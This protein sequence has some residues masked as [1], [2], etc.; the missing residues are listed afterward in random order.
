MTASEDNLTKDLQFLKQ[1]EMSSKISMQ[2]EKSKHL[3]TFKQS[4][5]N[6][7][8]K[9]FLQNQNFKD[10]RIQIDD[11]EFQVHKFILA[12]RSPTIADFMLQNSN[13]DFLILD[14][15]SVGIFEKILTFIYTDELPLDDKDI[16]YLQLFAAANQLDIAELKKFAASKIMDN[17]DQ[18]NAVEILMLGNK[19]KHYEMKQKAFEEIKKSYPEFPPIWMDKPKKVKDFIEVF[20]EYY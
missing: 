9:T 14:D 20:G 18:Q 4:S 6:L 15:I 19:H 17:I 16:N 1:S 7:E 5:L 2:L 13:A 8:I 11:C 12:A 10:F 3:Q